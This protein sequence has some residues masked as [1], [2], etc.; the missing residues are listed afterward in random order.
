MFQISQ[1]S[2]QQQSQIFLPTALISRYDYKDAFCKKKNKE[3]KAN[4]SG[5]A[6]LI[7]PSPMKESQIHKG[8]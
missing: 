3:K 6:T 7:H 1:L 5:E 8:K 2:Q 4:N